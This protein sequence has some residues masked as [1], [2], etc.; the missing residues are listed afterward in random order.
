MQR[1]ETPAFSMAL[2]IA[3]RLTYD[4]PLRGVGLRKERAMEIINL[5][6]SPQPSVA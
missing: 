5:G 2:V 1:W 4:T 6:G 3:A